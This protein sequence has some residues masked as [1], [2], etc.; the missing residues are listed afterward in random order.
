MKTIIITLVIT[1]IMVSGI[2]CKEKSDLGEKPPSAAV[3]TE[4][5][6]Q[7][8]CPVMGGPIDK[9]FY[10]DYEGRRVYF[11]CQACVDAFKKDP[12]K[13]LKNLPAADKLDQKT[14]APDAE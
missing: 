8:V 10:T 6:A 13:Y 11:C 4:M 2:A 3:D 12:Q 7:T 1:L 9:S 5:T 14:S